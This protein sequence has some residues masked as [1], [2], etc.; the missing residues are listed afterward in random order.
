MKN[1]HST[2]VK[3]GVT[4]NRLPNMDTKMVTKKEAIKELRNRGE[5][6]RTIT[7]TFKGRD[8]KAFV[9]IARRRAT[10]LGIIGAS[11]TNVGEQEVTQSSELGEK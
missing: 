4:I 6:K 3:V 8:L 7:R 9:T 1:K 5:L 11:D 10:C 2:Q